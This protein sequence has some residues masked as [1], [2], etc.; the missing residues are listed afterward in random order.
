MY[1]A[2]ALLAVVTLAV[3]F[4]V[5]LPLFQD[6]STVEAQIQTEESNLVAAQALLARR[7]SA[8]AQSAASEVELMR[9][10]NQ[11]PDSP[12]LPTVIIELQDV[13]NAAGIDFQ[14]I[15]PGDL[16]PGKTAADGTPSEYSAVPITLILRGD[17]ADH[18]DYFRRIQALDRGVRIAAVTFN[19]VPKSETDDDYVEANVT[20]EVYVMT[21]LNTA[22][23]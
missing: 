22:A 17:W 12:L 16:E 18:I 20:L 13:A 15:A 11:I 9:I 19:Y 2:V 23:Q 1:I 21:A 5:I 10:A 7:Q 4:F 3:A 14:S 6:A 8:K